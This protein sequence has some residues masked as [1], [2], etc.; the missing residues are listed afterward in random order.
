MKA[1]YICWRCSR[2][3]VQSQCQRRNSGFV[4]LGQLVGR[5]DDSGTALQGELPADGEP[6]AARAPSRKKRLAFAQRYQEQR[7]PKGVDIVLETIFESSRQHV[8]ALKESQDSQIA[9]SE[10]LTIQNKES[11]RLAKQRSLQSRL[12]NLYNNVRQGSAPLHDIWRDCESLL[13]ERNWDLRGAEA[14]GKDEKITLNTTT[15]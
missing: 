2:Q 15:S 5:K 7:K 10:T 9:K 13:D 3:F 14:S 8:Q 1:P 4:S 11:L 6:A 12:R